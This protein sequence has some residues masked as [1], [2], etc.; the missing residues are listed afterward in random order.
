MINPFLIGE[1]LYLRPL[2][3]EDVDGNYQ[4][5]LNDPELNLKNSHHV[6]PYT[7]D[8]LINYVKDAFRNRDKLPLAIVD[9]NDD[10]HVGN[11]SL[12]NIDFVN[13]RSDWGIIIGEREYWKK[14]FA[15]EA[16]FLLLRHAF[17]NLN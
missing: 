10:V 4:G 13:S 7:K 11:I 1:K 2:S 8:D 15:K 9:K 3:I 14:G 17:D 12:N 16:A 6:F 5:W